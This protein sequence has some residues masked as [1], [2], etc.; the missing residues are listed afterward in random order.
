MEG[1]GNNWPVKRAGDS[2]NPHAAPGVRD[3]QKN[4]WT[5]PMPMNASP[6]EEPEDAPELL[7]ERSENM[8]DREGA[9]W[10]QTTTGYQQTAG[11]DNRRTAGAHAAKS[12]QKQKKLT[13][14]RSLAKPKPIS[15]RQGWGDEIPYTSSTPSTYTKFSL[16]H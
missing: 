7:K 10:Q 4:T 16:T 9:F 5:G 12:P 6:F 13:L 2:N 8:S 14:P 1:P 15:H 3:W 11:S